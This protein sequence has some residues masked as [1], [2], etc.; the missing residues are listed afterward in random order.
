MR[1]CGLLVLGMV[2]WMCVGCSGPEKP[3]GPAAK[4]APRKVEPA[5]ITQLYF[6]P[7]TVARG[8]KSLLCYGVENAKAV[9]LSPPPQELSPSMSRCVD[10]TAPKTTT[11][12]LTAEADGA[13]PVSQ[14]VTLTVGAAHP[15]ILDV[16]VSAL[17]AKPGDLLSICYKVAN[18]Q[19]VRIDPIG[20]SKLSGASAGCTTAQ[21]KQTTTY[22]ITALGAAGDQDRE[23]VTVKVQ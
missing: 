19:S 12:T 8:E 14:E 11:Y 13:P 20:Y 21:L 15:K 3:A 1:C 2:V 6:S 7:P 18:A 23:N 5:R 10:V 16:T 4:S 22:T 17:T 9:R